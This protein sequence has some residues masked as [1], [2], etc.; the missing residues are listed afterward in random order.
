MFLLCRENELKKPEKNVNKLNGNNRLRDKT[1]P[2][3]V[4]YWGAHKQQ[5]LQGVSEIF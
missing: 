1:L 5:A 4:D 3:A 2:T